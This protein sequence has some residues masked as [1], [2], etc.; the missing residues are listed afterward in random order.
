M[1][2]INVVGE[3]LQSQPTQILASSLPGI[4]ATPTKVTADSTHIKI[5]WTAPVNTGG[6]SLLKYFVYVGGV[7][8]AEVQ[9]PTTE[10]TFVTSAGLVT[11][12]SYTFTV[13]AVNAIG[14]GTKSSA[15]SIIA[16]TVPETM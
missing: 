15:V 10:Y 9:A 6:S 13:S 5:S 14:E 16:A 1:S 11:G 8:K 2:S 12:T 7:K 4:P 3:S